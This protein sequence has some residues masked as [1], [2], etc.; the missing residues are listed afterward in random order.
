MFLHNQKG[1]DCF[2]NGIYMVTVNECI[3]NKMHWVFIAL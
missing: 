3:R 2:E 1:K